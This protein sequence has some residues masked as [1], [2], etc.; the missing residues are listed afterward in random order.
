MATI[1]TAFLGIIRGRPGRHP[2]IAHSLQWSDLAHPARILVKNPD[3]C[4]RY[5]AYPQRFEQ[6]ATLRGNGTT[7]YLDC[8]MSINAEQVFNTTCSCIRSS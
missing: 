4:C 3:G 7:G 5:D 6:E 8:S 1:A 2:S